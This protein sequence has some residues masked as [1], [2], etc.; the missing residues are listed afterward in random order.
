[1]F[2]QSFDLIK[3]RHIYYKSD[4]ENFE[5]EL[6]LS[7]SVTIM[8]LWLIEPKINW[9]QLLPTFESKNRVAIMIVSNSEL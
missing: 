1:M 7:F 9:N 2:H 6:L 4:L 5:S 8:V 3:N